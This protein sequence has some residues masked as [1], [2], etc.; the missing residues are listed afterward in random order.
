MAIEKQIQEKV[1]EILA[2]V[3]ESIP[4]T[5]KKLLVHLEMAESG[6]T[7]YFFF[8]RENEEE[9]HY[10]IQ[11]PKEFNSSKHLF[12]KYYREQFKLTR[13]LWNIFLQNNLALWS[14]ATISLIDGE[15]NLIFDYTPWL[16]STFGPTDTLYYFMYQHLGYSPKNENEVRLFKEM[17]EYQK[18]FN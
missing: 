7:I 8:K 1:E 17:E 3:N 9:Y 16:E 10:S 4:T 18:Q 15:M 12:A 14:S 13:E 11:I 2:K 5:W 6:G